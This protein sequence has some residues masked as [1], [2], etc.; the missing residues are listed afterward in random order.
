MKRA[1]IAERKIATGVRVAPKNWSFKKGAKTYTIL[2]TVL[3]HY[4]DYRNEI[5]TGVLK[6]LSAARNSETWA[7]TLPERKLNVVIPLLFHFWVL[8]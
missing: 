4:W 8:R 3:N 7:D 5:Q 2:I 6:S 1:D